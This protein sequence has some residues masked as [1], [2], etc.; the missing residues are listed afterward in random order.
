[1]ATN[2]CRGLRWSK[3]HVRSATGSF[4]LLGTR[5]LLSFSFRFLG[6]RGFLSTRVGRFVATDFVIVEAVGF[7]AATP[8]EPA[9]VGLD[10]E[11]RELELA[12]FFTEVGESQILSPVCVKESCVVT[13]K[14]EA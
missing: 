2:A 6:D 4:A 10:S 7:G 12:D 13:S 1:M 14:A 8:E 3:V 5:S 9:E 11:L